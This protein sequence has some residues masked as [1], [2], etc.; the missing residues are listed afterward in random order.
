MIN[1]LQ[2][3][4]LTIGT[5]VSSGQII[6]TNSGWIAN[7]L[8]N[9]R[10]NVAWHITVADLKDDMLD[11]LSFLQKKSKTIVVTGGLGPT[12]DDFTRNIISQW[13]DSP[14]VFDEA[15]WQHVLDRFVS[16]GVASAPESNRQQCY[17]PKGARILTNRKGTA[18]GFRVESK[19][20]TLFVLP[21]P[22]EEIKAIWQDHIAAELSQNTAEADEVELIRWQCLGLSESKLGEMVQELIQDSSLI[23]GYRPHLPYVEIKI[24]CK[25]SQ[26]V[27]EQH[28]ID[29]IDAA[30]HRWVVSRGD[31]DVL[32][33]LLSQ[34]DNF[35]E[36][37]IDDQA[38]LGAIGHRIG[39]RWSP[40]SKTK[41]TIIDQLPSQATRSGKPFY[42]AEG[43]HKLQL[44]IGPI[45]AEGAWDV[46]F[47]SPEM[48]KLQSLKL[49]YKRNPK[50]MDRE[51]LYICELSLA[52]LSRMAD[53]GITIV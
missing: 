22:P 10:M 38:S 48:K 21:G 18:H 13:V 42:E 12:S 7:E 19:G 2:A 50:R 36:V 6:N 45:D 25:K 15:S 33:N 53:K 30:I 27:R 29:R 41:L 4:I 31:E 37:I 44:V 24:W 51:R 11:A 3:S 28:T 35:A 40:D 16:L 32:D 8:T 39:Q 20:V 14:L 9:L 49:P 47:K 46:W 26:R 1:T 34:F 5:E 43:S 23:A 17:F 52:A